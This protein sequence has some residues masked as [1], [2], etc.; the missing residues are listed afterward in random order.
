MEFIILYIASYLLCWLFSR[1]QSEKYLDLWLN[2]DC[3][4]N[5]FWLIPFLNSIYALMIVLFTILNSISRISLKLPKNK[6]FNTDL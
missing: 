3:G 5:I 2:S 6:F 4:L 1:L